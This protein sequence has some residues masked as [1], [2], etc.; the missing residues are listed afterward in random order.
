MNDGVL[1]Y[2]PTVADQPDAVINMDLDTVRD[3]GSRKMSLGNALQ[4]DRTGIVKGKK[5]AE[6][7]GSLIR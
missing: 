7:F 5:Y 1:L 2:Q 3:V 6:I 4:L